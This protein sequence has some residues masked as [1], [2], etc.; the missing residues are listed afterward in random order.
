MKQSDIKSCM[1]CGEGVMHDRQ[2][3]FY[4]VDVTHWI[5]DIGAIQ[6]QHG[7]E[8]HMGHGAALAQILGPDEDIA[9]S[10]ESVKNIWVCQLCANTERMSEIIDR[11]AQHKDPTE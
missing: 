6:R 10:M 5:V 3:T 7:L 9:K 11:A 1:S 8:Q 4:T 2:M